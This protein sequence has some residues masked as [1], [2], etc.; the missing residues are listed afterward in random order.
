M[1]VLIRTRRPG[2]VWIGS[3]PTCAR[4]GMRVSNHPV[5]P[6]L[7]PFLSTI[8]IDNTLHSINKSSSSLKWQVNCSNGGCRAM[9]C[10]AVPT[11]PAKADP[12][13]M[14]NEITFSSLKKEYESD[15]YDT[16]KN[17]IHDIRS[18]RYLKHFSCL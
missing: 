8:S 2:T 16:P 6:A 15:K 10:H 4:I 13:E 3:D 1:A 17:L 18:S 11:R 14:Q 5:R 12:E 7:L 9:P